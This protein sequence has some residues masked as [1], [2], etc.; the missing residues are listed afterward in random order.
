MAAIIHLIGY[1]GV[2]KRTVAE[3]IVATRPADADDRI[4][5]VDNHLTSNPILAVTPR[6]ATGRVPDRVWQIVSGVRAQVVLA[7]EELSPP[8]WSFVFTNVLRRTDPLGV[9]TAAQLQ[10]LAE[11]RGDAYVPVLL[12]CAVDEQ[13]R[14]VVAPERAG[15]GKWTDADGVE[16]FVRTVGLIVP[17]GPNR[18]DLDITHRQPDVAAAAILEHVASC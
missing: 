7:I 5:L 13:R 11:T 1:P 18:I 4:V 3:A 8:G 2:G 17:E 12:T 15:R 16:E 10:G 6:T 9:T 14:R